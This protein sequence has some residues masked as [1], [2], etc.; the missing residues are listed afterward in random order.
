MS[1]FEVPEA[2]ICSPFEEPTHHWHLEEGA[3]PEKRPGRRPAIYY[4]PE[5]LPQDA[6]AVTA[7][8]GTAIELKLVSLIRSRTKEWRA[9]GYPGVTAT[10]LEL[11]NYWRR[12]GRAFR[13]FFAQL[14]AA[15]TTIFLNEARRDFVQGIELPRDEPSEQQ[16]TERGYKSFRRYACKMAT[17]SGKTTVMGMVAAW[18]ILNKV[19]DRSN[20]RY[21]DVVLVVCPM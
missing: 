1:D 19:H 10:T 20:G 3:D 12:E 2:I 4:Y 14:E 6:A 11:L 18:S 21:S 16:K 15:E 13:F 9:A 7:P 8:K 5:P 17:G